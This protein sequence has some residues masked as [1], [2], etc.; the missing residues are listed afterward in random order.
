MDART[1]VETRYKEKA[2]RN[3]QIIDD[4]RKQEEDGRE[5]L[6]TSGG[7]ASDMRDKAREKEDK[8]RLKE[9]EIR[10]IREQVHQRVA[11]GEELRRLKEKHEKEHR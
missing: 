1:A 7:Q 9:A 2:A 10:E 3:Q 11:R 6:R 8:I 5:A 4:L